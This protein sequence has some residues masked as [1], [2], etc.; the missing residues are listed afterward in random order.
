M[1]MGTDGKPLTMRNALAGPHR[2]RWQVAR[3]DELVKLVRG[4]STIAPVHRPADNPTYFQEVP[5][6][7]VFHP[8]CGSPPFLKF[9]SRGVAGGE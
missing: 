9:R 6:A 8:P 7:K 5:R 2:A 4:T 1:N 3:N